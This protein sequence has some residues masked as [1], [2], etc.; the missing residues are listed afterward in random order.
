MSSQVCSC[1]ALKQQYRCP[2]CSS[3]TG[4]THVTILPPLGASPQVPLYP[5]PPLLPQPQPLSHPLS[6][7]TNYVLPPPLPEHATPAKEASSERDCEQS[8]KD[9]L[10]S[11]CYGNHFCISVGWSM[12]EPQ[13][14]ASSKIP[15]GLTYCSCALISECC[16]NY[17]FMSKN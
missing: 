11:G 9:S 13:H 10:V 3:P 14:S 6:V 4:V 15:L 5:S 2:V 8:I 1:G 12:I 7:S 16:L 17:T